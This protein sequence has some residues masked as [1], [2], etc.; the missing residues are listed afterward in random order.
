[1]ILAYHRIAALDPDPDGLCVTPED[2]RDQMAHVRREYHPISLEGL[3]GTAAAGEIPDGAIAVTLDDGYLDSFE[4]ASPILVECGIPATFFV[5]TGHLD[6]PG[7]FWWD[8]VTRVL[9]S[10][11]RVP[12]LLDLSVD[13]TRWRMPTA[14]PEERARARVDVGER[15]VRISPERREAI[16]AGLVEW[17]GGELPPRPTHRPLL[18]GEVAE[19]ATRRGHMIGAHGV[20]HL[21]LPAQAPDVRIRETAESK[22]RLEALLGRPVLA[23]AYPYG[24]FD[25]VTMEVVRAAGFRVAVTTQDNRVLPYADPMCLPRHEIR[26]RDAARFAAVLRQGTHPAFPE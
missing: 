1:M 18:A 3:A 26:A 8:I 22:A 14:T 6:E 25:A 21:F 2:F 23:F 16:V 9:L 19:L 15:L 4:I 20:H 11:H 10:G 17:S 12:P 13:G 7:E 5:T 24:G